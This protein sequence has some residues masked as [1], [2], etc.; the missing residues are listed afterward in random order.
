MTR[1][2]SLFLREFGIA[3]A[4]IIIGASFFISAILGAIRQFLLAAQ[5][6]TGDTISA[7]YA[8]AKLP[9][10]LFTLIAGGALWTAMIPI[11]THVRLGEGADSERRLADIVL[12]AVMASAI[13]IVLVGQITAPLFVSRV[14]V[15]GF[16]DANTDLAIRLTRLLLIHPLIIALASVAMAVL[17]ARS[18]FLL[19]AVALAI[20]NFAEIA[21]IAAARVFPALGIYGPVLGVIAGALLQAVMLF[22]VLWPKEW[23]PRFNWSPRDRGLRDVLTLLVPTSLSL[24]V[25]YLGGVLDI[26][27]A[28][29]APEVGAIP[30]IVNAW[31]LVA[32]PVRM[33]GFA[34]GQ[35]AFP[36]LVAAANE[37]AARTFR[38]LSIRVGVVA[39]AC[40]IP[41]TVLLIV[42]ARTAIRLFY[43]H[44][45]FDASDGNLT[46]RV[47]IL[48]AA[49]L[50]A[51]VIT[52]VLTRSLVALRDTRTPLVTNI[53]QFGLRAAIA[54]PLLDRW[55]VEIIPA[56]FAI[57]SV[58]EALMLGIVLNRRVT[59]WQLRGR[60][61]E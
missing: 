22:W 10:T 39:F 21:G 58:I 11:L 48:Y 29:R 4:S 55:G 43:E 51:Y 59:F 24:G 20:H 34:A 50:P 27:L 56:A 40:S 41:I 49:G 2:R 19:P 47:V 23:R 16:D 61:R 57:S 6:G 15:P 44:G 32:L 31:L 8:A 26:A 38:R 52:E 17:N 18:R 54:I 1:L 60:S 46:S 45:E 25:G 37:S 28:S 36:R 9:E 33:I 30:A 35:G 12:T 42:V 3:E 5:Y 7:Y 13:A 53:M 14:L